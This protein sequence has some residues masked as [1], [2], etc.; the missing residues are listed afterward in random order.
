MN[1]DAILKDSAFMNLPP[2]EKVKVLQQVDSDFAGLPESEQ[3][4]VVSSMQEQKPEPP[5][6]NSFEGQAKRLGFA[7]VDELPTAGALAGGVIGAGSGLMSGGATSYPGAVIGSGIGA[8]IG[9]S[10]RQGVNYL[11]DRDQS[12]GLPEIGSEILS[13]A[14]S[15]AGGGIVANLAGRA[16]K[17]VAGLLGKVD[18]L[19]LPRFPFKDSRINNWMTQLVDMFP[20]GKFM[21]NRYRNQ[22][23]EWALNERYAFTKEFV[24]AISGR[25]EVG[26]AVGGELLN[27]A[28]SAGRAYDEFSAVA[29]EIPI[30]TETRRVAHKYSKIAN[31]S[32]KDV[33]AKLLRQDVLTPSEISK[34][35]GGTKGGGVVDQGIKKE[36]KEA[37]YGDL[38]AYDET[39]GTTMFHIRD[40]ADKLFSK[41]LNDLQ[42]NSAFQRAVRAYD[43]HTK[44]PGIPKNMFGQSRPD[45]VMTKMFATG[46]VDELQAIKKML[47]EDTWN[48]VMA[49]WL[50]ENL[51]KATTGGADN[52]DPKK[53]SLVWQEIRGKVKALAPDVYDR[54]STWTDIIVR[55]E[56][57]L[58]KSNPVAWG[59]ILPGLPFQLAAQGVGGVSGVA[60]VNAMPFIMAYSFL[61]PAGKSLIRQA[62]ASQMGRTAA[63]IG[64]MK[65]TEGL[66]GTIAE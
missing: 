51:S 64:T 40:S 37:I 4:R 18:E 38:K 22:I 15:E 12:R 3:A 53:W 10:A 45:L 47:P 41:M 56:P 58:K 55:A 63:K 28:K 52:L 20:G 5:V 49:R 60:A 36:L 17:P 61:G 54:M 1:I 14:A 34:M 66:Y 16:A 44:L 62:A 7:F 46:K 8:G 29:A 59:N 23:N 50:E 19:A 9:E 27:I 35:F 30:G 11:I 24:D 33:I 32:D 31:G 2:Q 25:G 65:A 6:D 48:M 42:N 21:T 39:M 57:E 13:G 43:P 26:E